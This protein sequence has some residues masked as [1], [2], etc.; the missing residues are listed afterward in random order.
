MLKIQPENQTEEVNMKLAFFNFI[1]EEI[2]ALFFIKIFTTYSYAVLY[3]S[4]ILYMTSHLGISNNVATGIVGVFISLNFLLHFLGGYAGGKY[5]SNRGLFALGM[6]LE[7]L[8]VSILS[9]NLFWGLGV[10]LTGC[11]LYA[12]SINAIMLQRYEPTDDRR[13]LASFWIYSGMN[14]GFFLGHTV[15]GYFHLK[16][17]YQT[18]FL[19]ALVTSACSL[20]L[21]FFNWKGLADKTTELVNIDSISQKKRLR[22]AVA[23]FAMLVP[24]VVFALKYEAASGGLVIA[25]GLFVLCAI[26]KFGINQKT[27]SERNK[28]F[29]FLILVLSAITFWSLFFIGP[30]GLTLFINK[31]VDTTMFNVSIPPQWFHNINTVIIV[32]GGPLLGSWLQRKR[33][34][35]V[36]ISVPV[37][38]SISLLLIGT[39]FAILPIGIKVCSAGIVSVE[40]VIASYIFQTFGEL[41]LSPVGVAMIG[42]LAPQGKQ[43]LLLGVWSM[44]SGIASML[45]KYFS[46]MMVVS[47]DIT[48]EAGSL[49]AFSTTFNIVGWSSI[50]AALLLFALVPVLKK[51][52]EDKHRDQ[53]RVALV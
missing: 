8:G 48:S 43:G 11:G 27:I 12:T 32:I 5:L 13:E 36:D 30:M 24:I 46:Q 14:L 47:K 39:A 20:V 22:M 2:R 45:S 42:K 31:H 1:P 10:F 49:H 23:V 41:C 21:M 44:V 6:C 35:G 33:K 26:L 28:I 15:S 19:S 7:I 3:A 53:K 50:L 18:L 16:G 17:D 9:F 29:A 51:L 34:V 25:T 40:W 4:L 52:M 37:L 38:F